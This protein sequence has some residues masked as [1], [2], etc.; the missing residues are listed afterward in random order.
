M[1][2][3][4]TALVGQVE[5]ALSTVKRLANSAE[6]GAISQQEAQERAKSV[7]RAIRYGKNDYFF[8][9]NFDGVNLAHG[10]KPENEGKNLLE[11]KDANGLRFNAA[12]IEAAKAGGG[13]VDF[14]FPRAGQDQPSPK[15]GYALGY[16]PWQWV[17]GTGTYIDDIDARFWELT[18]R[19][20]AYVAVLIALLIACAWPIARGIVRP[21]R[22]LTAA[23]SNLS[24][25]RLDEA[26][27]GSER[28]DEIGLMARAVQVFKEG[29]IA[30]QATEAVAA[31][32]ADAKMRR[33]NLLDDLTKRFEHNVSVLTQ[34]LAGAATEMEATAQTMT[35]TADETT[36]Q[37][38]SVVG[39]AKQTSANVQTVA[40]A[41]EEMAA[42][43]AEIA[44]QVSLS[45][46]IAHMAVEKAKGTDATVQRLAGTAERISSAVSIISTIA[47]QTNLLALNATIEAARAGE[48]G[49][50]FAVVATEVK[51]LAGQTSRATGEIGERIAEIQSATSEAVADIREIS[52]V[53]SEMSAYAGGIAA[54]MEEQGAAT[55][56]ITRN[57][58][59]AAQGTEEVTRNIAGVQDGA[60]QT[61]MAAGQVLSAAQELARHSVSLSQEVGTFLSSVKAA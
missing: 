35:V 55:Q 51:E 31:E 23:M 13:F 50:G 1:Q 57:V 4:R 7:L 53:I 60:G 43:V 30:K 54:A 28:G 47:S 37:T 17:I 42:S 12:L 49:R 2:E 15:L 6:Q 11:A 18:R 19:D 48:A 38:L 20:A 41:S 14:M 39:A 25:G 10:L 36:Q 33:A 34:G 29:L 3:R 45:A 24:A 52:R 32:E 61:S 27:P 21:I 9:Y 56:E 22:A 5:A 46:R 59:Q 40:A 8:V 58:Q 26:V 44:H 16:A